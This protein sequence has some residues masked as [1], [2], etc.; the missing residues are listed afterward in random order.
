M[1]GRG[2]QIDYLPTHQMPLPAPFPFPPC[3]LCLAWFFSLH[4][5][6]QENAAAV[7][8]LAAFSSAVP[9]IPPKFVLET[10]L[11]PPQLG[12]RLS[13]GMLIDA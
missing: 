9:S 2:R 4:G 6:L 5:I 8:T 3:R 11:H 13:L 1:F 7:P 12:G 10:V